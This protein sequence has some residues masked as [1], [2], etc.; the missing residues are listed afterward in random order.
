MLDGATLKGLYERMREE[1][2]R[3][4]GGLLDIPRRAA[5]LHGLYLDS[6]GNHTFPQIA[7]HGALWAW[8]FFEVGGSMGRF[9]A[10]RYFYTARERTYR[11]GL[12]NEF[13]EDFR[14]VN[15][16]VCIDTYTNYHF[17]KRYGREPAAAEV[18]PGELLRALNVVHQAREVGATLS[19]AEKRQVFKQSF[20][21]EQE[22]TV[23]PGVKAAVEKFH[24]RVM[25]FLCLHPIVRFAYFPSGR[26]LLFRNF[27]STGERIEKGL[28][29]YDFGRWGGW[30]RVLDTMRV[31]RLMPPA[32]FRDP[33]GYVRQLHEQPAT[34]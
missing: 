19:E 30:P 3:L 21:W 24:C 16:S 22:L 25:Q 2:A 26:F 33:A 18:M 29:A 23:A 17:S 13:A 8:N 15:R 7:A 34:A 9:I 10:R 5:L 28:R 14:R 1:T 4:A 11:L 6:G 12:L 32:F 27:A 31:Y 20:Y